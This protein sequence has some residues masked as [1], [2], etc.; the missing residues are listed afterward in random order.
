MFSPK[1]RIVEKSLEIAES[2]KN[3]LSRGNSLKL[4]SNGNSKK[5]SPRSSTF[6]KQT[7][8][9]EKSTFAKKAENYYSPDKRSNVL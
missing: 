2:P 6:K 7:E 5:N 8:T 9:V 1:S 4:N 3:K